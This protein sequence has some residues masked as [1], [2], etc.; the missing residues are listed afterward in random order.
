MVL[1]CPLFAPAPRVLRSSQ[2]ASSATTAP[3]TGSPFSSTITSRSWPLRSGGAAAIRAL[4]GT[5]ITMKRA[6]RAAFILLPHGE[7]G[8]RRP[9]VTRN[10]DLEGHPDVR[11][12]ADDRLQPKSLRVK[13]PKLIELLHVL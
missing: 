6:S 11:A 9:R 2:S 13:P 8:L 1:S 4:S 7:Y 3:D 12:R 10:E 5:I